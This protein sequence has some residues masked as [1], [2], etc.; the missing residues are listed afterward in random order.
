MVICNQMTSLMEVERK[1]G[2][3]VQKDTSGMQVSKIELQ[4]V[5]GVLI[6]QGKE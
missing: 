6:V 2:G 5:R 4:E 1:S 3:F